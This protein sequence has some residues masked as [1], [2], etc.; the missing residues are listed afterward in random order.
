MARAPGSNKSSD[1]HLFKA[2]HFLVSRLRGQIPRP[3]S[4]RKCGNSH[5]STREGGRSDQQSRA[6]SFDVRGGIFFLRVEGVSQSSRRVLKW[7]SHEL[8]LLIQRGLLCSRAS[9]LQGSTLLSLR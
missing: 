8:P 7:A 1:T 9:F 4:K 2:S 6:F 3:G 5:G